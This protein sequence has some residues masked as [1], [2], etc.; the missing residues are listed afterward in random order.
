MHFPGT[1]LPQ[2]P[3]VEYAQYIHSAIL[4]VGRD[5]KKSTPFS[6]ESILPP[7]KDHFQEIDP[8]IKREHITIFKYPPFLWILLIAKINP[9]FIIFTEI[10]P[11]FEAEKVPLF[12]KNLV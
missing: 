4:C 9:F 1:F 7:C 6:R 11:N 10:S 5:S 8:F 2:T 3:R 12:R